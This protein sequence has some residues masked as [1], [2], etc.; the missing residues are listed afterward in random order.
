[1]ETPP[2]YA[3][4]LAETGERYSTHALFALRIAAWCALASMVIA[5]HALLPFLFEKTGSRL[6]CRIDAALKER[7]S[8]RTDGAA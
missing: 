6:L 5:V 4:H 8:P 2:W 7:R 3:R 1:M